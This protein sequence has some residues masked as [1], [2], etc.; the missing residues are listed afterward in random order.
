MQ[1]LA[2]AKLIRGRNDP[3]NT[4]EVKYLYAPMLG[5]ESWG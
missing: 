1:L 4:V 3:G 2:F 5:K